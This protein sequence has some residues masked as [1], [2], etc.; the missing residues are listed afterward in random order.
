MEALGDHLAEQGL[1]DLSLPAVARRAGVGIA[2][3]YRYYP[4]RESLLEAFNELV[5]ERL[6][7]VSFDF[8]EEEL[9]E[10]VHQASRGFDQM[11]P[12][13]EGA[14]NVARSRGDFAAI[15]RRRLEA[16]ERTLDGATGTLPAEEAHL[17]QRE[18]HAHRRPQRR[19]P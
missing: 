15:S 6:G 19:L 13:L 16:L 8:T 17:V 7:L 18:A 9:P 10:G 14:L 12:L 2:T 3:I 4:D 11:A 1:Q 5:R